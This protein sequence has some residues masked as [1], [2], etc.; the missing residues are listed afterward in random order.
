MIITLTYDY[1]YNRPNMMMILLTIYKVLYNYIIRF[2]KTS[3][4]ALYKSKLTI[5]VILFI[6]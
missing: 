2:A 3:S 5:N 1:N 6:V 4:Q